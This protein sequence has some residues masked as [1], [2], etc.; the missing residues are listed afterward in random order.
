MSKFPDSRKPIS[1]MGLKESTLQEISSMKDFYRGKGYKVTHKTH[2]ANGDKLPYNG[3][4]E[5]DR[6]R[7]YLL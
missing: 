6:R 2:L 1:V 3:V 4:L 7:K 5:V